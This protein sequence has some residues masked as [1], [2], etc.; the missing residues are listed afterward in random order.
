MQEPTRG[1]SAFDELIRA[2]QKGE[3][4]VGVDTVKF[5]R[6]GSPFYRAWEN[7]V[8]G[9]VILAAVI[10][11]FTVSWLAGVVA[12]ACGFLFFVIFVRRFVMNRVRKRVVEYALSDLKGWWLLWKEGALSLRRG[13]DHISGPEDYWIDFVLVDEV[14]APLESG[15]DTK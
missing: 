6:R 9:F 8:P 7:S 5:N 11:N 2:F 10:Y 13:Q 1:Q 12:L 14:G 3:I 4:E 15:R